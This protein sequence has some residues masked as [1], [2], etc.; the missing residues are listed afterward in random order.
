MR[1]KTSKK[2][3]TRAPVRRRSSCK[4]RNSQAQD[5]LLLRPAVRSHRDGALTLLLFGDLGSV[6]GSATRRP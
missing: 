3:E 1:E 6:D 2:T 5:A 4:N